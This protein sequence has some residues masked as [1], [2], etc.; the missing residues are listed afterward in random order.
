MPA[1]TLSPKENGLQD[2]TS[3]GEQNKTFFIRVWK[4]L[5]SRH[6]LKTLRRSPKGKALAVGLGCYKRDS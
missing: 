6:V 3:V 5:S 1:R 4:S 2:L